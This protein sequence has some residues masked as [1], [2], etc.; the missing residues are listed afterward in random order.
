MEGKDYKT[1]FGVFVK[2]EYS[3]AGATRALGLVLTCMGYEW[4][5]INENQ[6]SHQWIELNMDGKSGWADGQMGLA[7]YGE[8]NSDSI[9][10]SFIWGS[11]GQG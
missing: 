9:F 7:N 11:I 1:P 8:H 4:K 3:C 2:G 6:Y 5:H 10:D